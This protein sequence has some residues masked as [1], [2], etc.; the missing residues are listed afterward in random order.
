M[1]DLLLKVLFVAIF[2]F[3]VGFIIVS[4]HNA[5]KTVVVIEGNFDKKPL[6]IVLGQYQDS[7]CGMTIDDITYASQVI[8]PNGKTWFFHDHGGLVNWLESKSFKDSAVIWVWAIDTSEWIDGRM[9]R[10]SVDETT[11]MYYG[12]GAYFQNKDGLIDFETMSQKM[13][14]GEN[15]SNPVYAKVIKES[16]KENNGNN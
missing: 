11:P 9:A 4:N 5:S 3:V 1:K 8:A 10:Y 14:R 6:E 7:D 12:F 2:I 15:M 16:Y 13:L